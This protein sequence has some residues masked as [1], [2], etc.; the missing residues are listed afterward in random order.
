MAVKKEAEHSSSTLFEGHSG[1][2]VYI[3]DDEMEN[4]S[5]GETMYLDIIGQS[6]VFL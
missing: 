4:S 1:H 2:L 5:T 3:G 6:D